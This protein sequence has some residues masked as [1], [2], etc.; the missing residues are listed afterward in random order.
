MYKISIQLNS[1][2]IIGS[3]ISI[4]GS[5]DNDIVYSDHGLPIIKGRTLKGNLR[6]ALE[7]LIALVDEP[8][9][10]S[11][12]FFG[13]EGIYDYNQ[14]IL[15]IS[16]AT[17]SDSLKQAFET[18][19]YEK[20]ISS[21]EMKSTL[22]NERYFTQIENGVVKPESLRSIRTVNSGLTLWSNLS[23]K[24]D[25]TEEEL[26]VL[27]ASLSM[28]KHIGLMRSR[29]KGEVICRLWKEDEDLTDTYLNCF[30]RRLNG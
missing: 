21:E 2:T 5:V 11:G 13:T 27:C 10:L 24:R 7:K 26:S 14:G 20:K 1:E 6:E 18:A 30:E 23:S 19:I 17:L 22:T 4:P 25:L 9:N 29:G 3:G 8:E 15:R 28:V 16:D 12:V